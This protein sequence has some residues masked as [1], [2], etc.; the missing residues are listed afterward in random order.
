MNLI[1]HILYYKYR[2]FRRVWVLK[3][4]VDVFCIIWH[5]IIEVIMI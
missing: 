2:Q 5:E 4:L 1:H 3:S